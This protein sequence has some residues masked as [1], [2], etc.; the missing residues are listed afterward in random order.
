M[1]GALSKHP[2]HRGLNNI[3][4]GSNPS[5]TQAKRVKGREQEGGCASQ[6]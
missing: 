1:V 3:T 5:G 4:Q 6:P 2:A